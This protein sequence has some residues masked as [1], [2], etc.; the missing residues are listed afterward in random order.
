[1]NDIALDV[2]KAHIL[3]HGATFELLPLADKANY[4]V[5]ITHPKL[6]NKIEESINTEGLSQSLA[7]EYLHCKV[8]ALAAKLIAKLYPYK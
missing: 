3:G 4:L 2:A 7:E 5:V 1:M 6:P 8:H